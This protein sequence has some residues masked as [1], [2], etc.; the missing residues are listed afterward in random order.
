MEAPLLLLLLAAVR[1]DAY[2]PV[3]IVH[4]IF[5]GPKQFRTLSAFITEA[6]PG[7]EVTVID[8]YDNLSSLKPLW[9]QVQHFRRAASTVM[10]AAPDGVHLLCFSQGGLICRALLATT[11]DH[12]VHTFISLSSPQAGQYGGQRS[13]D[14]QGLSR[15]EGELTRLCP[16]TDTDYLN[17]V[18]PECVKKTVYYFCYRRLGQRVSICD[19]W[20]DPHHR[21]SYLQNNVFL[22]LLNGD[23]PH[24]DMTAWREN[25][26]RIQRLVLIGGPDDGVI[27]PWQ[28]S[29]F[30]FYDSSELVVEMRKQEFYRNDTFGLRTL[31]ARGAVSVCIWPEVKHVQWHSNHSVFSSCMEKWLT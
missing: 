1:V 12:N 29:H 17:R 15:S 18:F 8:L 9:T 13:C 19:Y 22:P 26:L 28:S 14:V 27:T 16:S 7:T 6:H 21:S 25:F 11:P 10:E 3:I 24:E 20:N 4:G 23:R 2:R 31:D 30:G 5:D